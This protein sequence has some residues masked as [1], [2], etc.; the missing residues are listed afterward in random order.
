MRVL[1][2]FATSEVAT[3]FTAG[4]EAISRILSQPKIVHGQGAFAGV[5][6]LNFLI[7]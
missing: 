7:R 6:R 3:I 5:A 2:G 4:I 1:V